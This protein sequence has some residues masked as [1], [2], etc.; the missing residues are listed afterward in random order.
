MKGERGGFRAV[1]REQLL[2]GLGHDSYKSKVKLPDLT[3]CPGCGAV[4]RNG[5][6]TWETATKDAHEHTCPAC[7][8]IHD[9]FPAGYV[10]LR[11][12]FHSARRQLEDTVRVMRGDVKVHG[13]GEGNE[14]DRKEQP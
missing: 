10:A 8:R 11:E 14:P 1:R 13:T 12:A 5:R 4:F 7:Q 9:E 2:E 3:R 6:W